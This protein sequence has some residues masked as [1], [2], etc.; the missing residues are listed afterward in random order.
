[1]RQEPPQDHYKVLALPIHYGTNNSIS[2]HD[3]K[4]A[5]RNALLRHHPDKSDSIKNAKLESSVFAIDQVKLAYKTL[6]DP[7][8]R[9]NYDH[10]L[11]L[12]TS[13]GKP[14]KENP[15]LGLETLDLDD[16]NFQEVESRWYSSC[17]CGNQQGF[18]VTEKDLESNAAYGEVI[19]ECRGCSLWLRVTFALSEDG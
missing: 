11:R 9:L 18:V 15:H 7:I 19:A 3:I 4:L 8:S 6:S 5:Y 17:R 1:M 12:I 13:E 16:L 10:T 2:L 14:T